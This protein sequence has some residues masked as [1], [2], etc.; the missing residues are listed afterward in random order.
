MQLQRY[1]HAIDNAWDDFET[2]YYATVR[3]VGLQSPGATHAAT[4]MRKA[5]LVRDFAKG[6][7]GKANRTDGTPEAIRNAVAELTNLKRQLNN[8]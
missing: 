6:L 7:L 5:R 1:T 2:T 8:V 4:Y 3:R